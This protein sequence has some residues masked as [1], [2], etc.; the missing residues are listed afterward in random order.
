MK[1]QTNCHLC[2]PIVTSSSLACI[3]TNGAVVGKTRNKRREKE[4]IKEI[5]REG[6]KKKE[7]DFPS[8]FS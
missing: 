1:N 3:K 8:L 4:K 2:F 6:Q 7:D 5:E